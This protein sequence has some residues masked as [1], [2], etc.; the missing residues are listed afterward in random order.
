MSDD[1]LAMPCSS[2]IFLNCGHD[3]MGLHMWN[4][5]YRRRYTSSMYRYKSLPCGP[6]KGI[7]PEGWSIPTTNLGSAQ[8]AHTRA[9][10]CS[11]QSG[12][13]LIGHLT[14]LL[15]GQIFFLQ[16]NIN[17]NI[18]TSISLQQKKATLSWSWM[19]CMRR[20]IYPSLA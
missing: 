5:I 2:N 7:Q 8:P 15:M 12:W 1:K 14:N 13:L 19:K 11:A 16:I 10:L 17:I 3:N 18:Q 9:S 4:T 6:T 20:L